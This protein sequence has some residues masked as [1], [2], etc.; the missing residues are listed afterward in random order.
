MFILSLFNGCLQ[1]FL[2]EFSLKADVQF[3]KQANSKSLLP[4]LKLHSRTMMSELFRRSRDDFDAVLKLL[5]GVFLDDIADLC[6]ERCFSWNSVP[7]PPRAG[8]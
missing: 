7:V 4:V 3:K 8:E 1:K 2:L 5:D 6:A